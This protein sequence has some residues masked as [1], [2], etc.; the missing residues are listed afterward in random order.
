MDEVLNEA[1]RLV[2]EA[3][4]TPL[5]KFVE[6]TKDRQAVLLRSGVGWKPGLVG[7]LQL[8]VDEGSA[9]EYSLRQNTPV[10]SPDRATETRFH[11]NELLLGHGV[12]AFVNVLVKSPDDA[13]PV[14]IFEVDST[15]PRAF[16][17]SDVDF[18]RGYA[19]LLAGAIARIEF[20]AAMAETERQ[21][22]ENER[23]MRI[24]VALNPQ[25]PWTADP[26][27]EVTSIDQ[28]WLELTGQHPSTVTQHA[29][30][31]LVHPDDLDQMDAA[32]A[33]AIATQEPYDVQARFRAGAGQYIW[34]RS[35]AFPSFDERGRCE[36]WYG[37]LEEISERVRIEESL[38]QWNEALEQR[39]EER[40]RQY[41][42][43]QDERDAAEAKLRQSQKMEAVGQ[44]TGGIAHDF[45]NMLASIATSLE[46]MQRRLDAGNLEKLSHYNVL[47]MTSVRRAAALT[48]RLLAFSRQ[49]PLAPKYVQP[50]Q[51]I[52][53]LEELIRRTVGP[54]IVVTTSLSANDTIRCDPHQ[55]ENA[56]L[57]LAINARDAMP[58]GGNLNLETRRHDIQ[59]DFAAARD[60]Q[61]GQYIGI[62][63]TD[64]GTGMTPEVLARAFDPFFTTKKT[65]QGTGLGLSM[66]YGFAQQSGGQVR[67]HSKSGIGTTVT[68]FFP[69]QEAGEVEVVPP[70]EPASLPAA[71]HEETI[72]FVDDETTVRQVASEVLRELGYRVVEAVDSKSAFRQVEKAGKIDLLIADI[73]LPGAMNGVSLADAIRPDHP[74]LKVLFIT[75]FASN[76]VLEKATERRSNRV[77]PKPFTLEQLSVLVRVLLDSQA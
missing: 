4:E 12:E 67:I 76:P 33:K 32:W 43:S 57:N 2:S 24:S 34:F 66:I 52:A 26:G 46:L 23:R 56:L 75:G 64:T 16:S 27:G 47:A 15:E 50:S 41:R 65:G 60:L 17:D 22:R 10:V 21:L 40:T 77:L 51:I 61:A 29:W 18:L 5:A 72:L 37:T 54:D 39:V 30:R 59:G 70:P 58:E 6:F 20:A 69:W 19:N 25:M 63:V 45:N 53:G 44:L 36:Q 8:G 55:L 7:Q 68:M 73:G 62:S 14:G 31:D 48:H 38:R 35:R 1:C 13:S 28:R 11:Y 49:Q 74:R 42:Q 3:L 9:E 71:S